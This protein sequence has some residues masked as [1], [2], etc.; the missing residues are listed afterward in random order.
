MSL[1]IAVASTAGGIYEFG[2]FRLNPCA[3]TLT[4]GVEPLR[5]RGE[6]VHRLDPLKTPTVDDGL[7]AAAARAFF[8][9]ELFYERARARFDGFEMR[10]E[11]VSVV[12]ELCRK[13][14]GLPLAI[15]LAVARFETSGIR[16]LLS[17]L[18][19]RFSALTVGRRTA[20]PRHQTLRATPVLSAIHSS[21]PSCKSLGVAVKMD[22][23][24]NKKSPSKGA[25]CGI[26]D[27][28][29][30]RRDRSANRPL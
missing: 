13:L 2:D 10:V 28:H 6:Q 23:S 18:E 3:R 12:G 9:I 14:D 8:A 29:A 7:S 4:N 17:E 26:E 19:D 22:S 1:T 30:P 21:S 27:G 15:E 5:A 20:L 11:D 16:G 24:L 25:K